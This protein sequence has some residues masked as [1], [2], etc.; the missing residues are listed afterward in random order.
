MATVRTLLNN[1]LYLSVADREFFDVQE[2]GSYINAALN[3]L[4]E[5]VDSYRH[6]VPFW[7]T[8]ELEGT[9]TLTDV[10]MASINFMQYVLGTVF[11]DMVGVSQQVFSRKKRI[12]NLRSIPFYYFH[13]KQNNKIDI[14]P[15]AQQTSDKFIIGYI[16]TVSLSNLDL[17]LPTSIPPFYQLFLEYETASVL[18]DNYTITWSDKKETSRRKYQ[19][20]LLM[21]S[22]KEIDPPRKRVLRGDRTNVPWEAYL[23]GNFPGS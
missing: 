1:A 14:Y 20:Q 18:C 8:E 23:A 12:E 9:S 15:A 6:Y 21:N 22:N 10:N 13:D 11:T 4:N 3:I 19:Q 7:F 17:E 5:L 2:S 16:P